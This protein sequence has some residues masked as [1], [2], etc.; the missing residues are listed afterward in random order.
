MIKRGKIIKRDQQPVYAESPWRTVAELSLGDEAGCEHEAAEKV[1]QILAR[2]RIPDAV[3]MEAKQAVT[4][5]MERELSRP[6]SH[7][8]QR[9]FTILIRAQAAHLPESPSDCGEVPPRPT[10]WGFFLTGKMTRDTELGDET[11]HVVM[12]LYLY[13]EGH[14]A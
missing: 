13:Q 11:H 2:V 10:G 5:T 1:G 4:R 14:L 7:Q 6:V 9:T 3:L 8:A 12:S